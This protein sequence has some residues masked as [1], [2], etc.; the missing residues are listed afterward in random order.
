MELNIVSN[1]P[2]NI[3]ELLCWFDE[4]WD[5]PDMIEDVKEQVLET[6]SNLFMENGSPYYSCRH[7]SSAVSMDVLIRICKVLECDVGD[8]MELILD[9]PKEAGS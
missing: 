8:V 7:S 1:E 6:I 4:I 9:D 3:K 5:H 2:D